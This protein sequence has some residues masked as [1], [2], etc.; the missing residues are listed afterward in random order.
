M[1]RTTENAKGFTD[2]NDLATRSCLGR[3]GLERQ[4]R[5]VVDTAG[6]HHAGVCIEQKA[7]RKRTQ[8]QERE[9][10]RG[11]PVVTHDHSIPRHTQ[12]A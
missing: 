4:V 6:K 10:R 3:E 7:A 5:A 2:F 12:S 8:G 1:N 9:S 11:A